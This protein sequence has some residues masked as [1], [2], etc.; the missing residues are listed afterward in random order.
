MLFSLFIIAVHLFD[1]CRKFLQTLLASKCTSI[2]TQLF[3]VALFH[4]A[5]WMFSSDGRQYP[6][7]NYITDYILNPFLNGSAILINFL[8][9]PRIIYE[10]WSKPETAEKILSQ[11][12]KEKVHSIFPHF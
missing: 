7:C 11:D 4:G 3:I 5:L 2:I 9:V 1:G 8:L 10:Y 12:V 6:V